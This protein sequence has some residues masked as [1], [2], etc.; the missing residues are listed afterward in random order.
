MASHA[1]Q[2]PTEVRCPKHP[3]VNAIYICL[4][5]ECKEALA[6][7][8]CNIESG[9]HF[10][11]GFALLDNHLEVF[12]K[13]IQESNTITRDNV[14][15]PLQT[16]AKQ[17]E[18]GLSGFDNESANMTGNVEARGEK[19]ISHT[20]GIVDELKG[21]YN[22][23]R[24][25]NRMRLEQYRDS[26]LARI[27]EVETDL[28]AHERCLTENHK[29][30]I[31]NT[32]KTG[33]T[34]TYGTIGYPDNIQEVS[35][36]ESESPLNELETL[37]GSLQVGNDEQGR[38][39]TEAKKN[40][41][42]E[43]EIRNL[44]ERQETEAGRIKRLENENKSLKDGKETEAEKNKRL[45]AEI[46]S[47]KERKETE[48]EKNKRLEAEIRSLKERKTTDDGRIKEL[49]A[50]IRSLKEGADRCQS[51]GKDKSSCRCKTCP[52][53]QYIGNDFTC[54]KQTNSLVAFWLIFREL[55]MPSPK[56]DEYKYLTRQKSPTQDIKSGKKSPHIHRHVEICLIGA[57]E[58][59]GDLELITGLPTYAQTVICT[60]EAEVYVLDQKNYDRLIEKR[61]P[62][63]IEMMK[64]LLMEKYKLRLSWIQDNELPFIRYLLYKLEEKERQ[65]RQRYLQ[66][67]ISEKTADWPSDGARR[68]PFI[69]MYGPG[70]V[71]YSIRMREKQ[72]K[73]E[74]MRFG[75]QTA[76]E[77]ADNASHLNTSGMITQIQL[78]PLEQDDYHQDNFDEEGFGLTSGSHLICDSAQE[79]VVASGDASPDDFRDFETSEDALSNLEQRIE[80]WHTSLPSKDSKR[81]CKKTVKLHRLLLED[82][83]KP[84]P[85][86]KVYLR[87]KTRHKAN[88][89]QDL[90]NEQTQN[91]DT[92]HIYSPP[93]SDVRA[94][95]VTVFSPH[96]SEKNPDAVC[97]ANRKSPW[98]PRPQSSRTPSVSLVVRRRRPTSARQYTVAEYEELKEQL[99]QK[100]RAFKSLLW[101]PKV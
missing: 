24:M 59:I 1:A 95:H 89:I 68:G 101:R 75:R 46:R 79:R 9:G 37:I 82:S 83:R 48:A 13:R 88:F 33:I 58:I 31:V 71:F 87:P 27:A 85:G 47:L 12:K 91:K 86:K 80:A 63:V 61:N 78:S 25:S 77:K 34:K 4:E 100:Q 35:F 52:H 69:D 94:P 17:V 50:E 70:S 60:Q 5:V 19:I 20:K 3:T 62:Q 32:A 40:K 56:P 66:R 15:V 8:H 51:C 23:I 29:A 84:L 65:K 30:D 74:R 57:L 10:K 28:A 44:K 81:Q 64:R 45:E 90:K 72:K 73:L 98:V 41:R 76:K 99:R 49:D 55:S 42:L 53:C 39:E 21:K 96:E 38:K 43:A 67:N 7:P 36:N 18:E 16:K 54:V 11:H 97:C 93:I 26:L 6:C 22:Q 2:V 92:S 14:L